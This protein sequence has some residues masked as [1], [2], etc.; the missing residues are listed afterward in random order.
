M[1]GYNQ[2]LADPPNLDL[3]QAVSHPQSLDCQESAPARRLEYVRDRRQVGTVEAP[4]HFSAATSVGDIREKNGL[5]NDRAAGPL[6]GNHPLDYPQDL[7]GLPFK[8]ALAE[9]RG[10]CVDVPNLVQIDD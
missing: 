8:I 9:R 5:A 1:A 10:D 6:L 2:F 3:A 4:H 7:F